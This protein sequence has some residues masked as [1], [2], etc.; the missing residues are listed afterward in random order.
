MVLE[1]CS[2][3]VVVVAVGAI[4]RGPLDHNV[5]SGPVSRLS[6]TRKAIIRDKFCENLKVP[7]MGELAKSKEGQRRPKSHY[8]IFEIANFRLFQ[9]CPRAIVGHCGHGWTCGNASKHTAARPRASRP[10]S[11]PR[12][13]DVVVAE[14]GNDKEF[15][16]PRNL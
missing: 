9:T 3:A 5:S 16:I 7:L 12:L 4:G 11:L 6:G 15:Q 13:H 10:A 1:V 2:G 14:H 8:Q